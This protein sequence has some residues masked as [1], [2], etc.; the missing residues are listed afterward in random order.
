[1]FRLTN[2]EV[3]AVKMPRVVALLVG[4]ID[5]FAVYYSRQA[6]GDAPLLAEVDAMMDR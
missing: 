5:L 6:E 2:G 3:P 4:Q 1:M